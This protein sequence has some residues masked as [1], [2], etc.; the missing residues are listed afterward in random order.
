[1]ADEL[2][3]ITREEF[4]KHHQ[5]AMKQLYGRVVDAAIPYNQR[6]EFWNEYVTY[7]Q[8][9]GFDFKFYRIG[10]DYVFEPIPNGKPQIPQENT[11]FQD[12]LDSILGVK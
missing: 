3:E 4:E 5:G 8:K 7:I 2:E 1:M 6:V 9:N 12:Y 11:P 10:Y